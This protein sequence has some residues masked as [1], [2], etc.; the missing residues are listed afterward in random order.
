[1]THSKVYTPAIFV[2]GVALYIGLRF[3]LEKGVSVLGGDNVPMWLLYCTTVLNAAPL[4]LPGVL[5]GI[6]ALRSP[7][8]L[9]FAVMFL[10]SI[11][12]A[13]TLEAPSQFFRESEVTERLGYTLAAGVFMGLI[14]ICAGAAGYYFSAK[15]RSDKSL[16]RTRGK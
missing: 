2:G 3:A 4:L 13:V 6:F 10:G 8:L 5:V 1:M 15:A 11:I 16:E 7:A 12:A 9:G 14:G